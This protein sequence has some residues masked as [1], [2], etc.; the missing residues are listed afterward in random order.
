[1]YGVMDSLFDRGS[2][3]VAGH[4]AFWKPFYGL[5]DQYYVALTNFRL[6]QDV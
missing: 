6:G 3:S 4:K 2:I 1:L 5:D